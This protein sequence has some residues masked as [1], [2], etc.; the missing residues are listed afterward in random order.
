MRS[1]LKLLGSKQIKENKMN[2]MSK[3]KT[4]CKVFLALLSLI[5]CFA[6]AHKPAQVVNRGKSYYGKYNNFNKDKYRNV[7]KKTAVQTGLK[8]HQVEVGEGDT[9]YTISRKYQVP[10]RDL[11]KQNNL[12]PPYKL[13]NGD[14]LTIPA[15]TYHEVEVGDTLYSIARLYKMNI[16]SLV[17]MNDLKAPYQ[18]EVGQRVRIMKFNSADESSVVVASKEKSATTEEKSKD[19]PGFIERTLDK[20]N[21]FSWPLH[22]DIIS[23][24]G[25]KEGGLYND[26]INIKAAEGDTVRVTEDGVVSYAGNELKGYGNL[27]IVKHSGGW[28]SAYAHLSKI[29]VKRGQKVSKMGKIGEVGSTGNVTSSQLYF[30]LRKGRDAVNPENYLGRK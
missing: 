29:S 8:N 11:I 20:M 2:N 22:G 5:F 13:N 12:V 18:L 27:I 28:I 21:H 6:C 16:D 3:S 24:F 4:S 17:E 14:K 30:G 26:G 23:K 19:S 9:I 15:P 7:G 10:L 25:P 1:A